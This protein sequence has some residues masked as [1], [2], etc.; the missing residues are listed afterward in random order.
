VIRVWIETSS[1]VIRAGFASLLE[2]DETVQLVDSPLE[3]D[4]IL[5]DELPVAIETPG[6]VPIVVV[7]DGPVSLRA[8]QGA[9][10]AILPSAAAT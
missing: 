6:S 7:T 5:R 2:S 8:F 10:R 1:S 4:V 3:A 9:V